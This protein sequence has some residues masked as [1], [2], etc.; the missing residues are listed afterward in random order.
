MMFDA[1]YDPI[2][3]QLALLPSLTNILFQNTLPTALHLYLLKPT[4]NLGI[5][6]CT[7]NTNMTLLGMEG[8]EHESERSP[9]LVLI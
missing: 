1:T 7:R 9:E 8:G 2:D 5:C 4:E 3:C 6:E